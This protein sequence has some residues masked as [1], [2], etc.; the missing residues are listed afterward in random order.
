LDKAIQ[1]V[2]RTNLTSVNINPDPF[3][4]EYSQILS[5]TVKPVEGTSSE[6]VEQHLRDLGCYK[7]KP[8]SVAKLKVLL[9]SFLMQAQRLEEK[10]KRKGERRIIGW[11]HSESYWGTRSSIGYKLAREL[12]EALVHHGWI[13]HEVTAEINLYL[14]NGHCHGY[15]IDD[16]VLDKAKDLA[17]TSSHNFIYPTKC[18]KTPV[19][20]ED[21]IDNR[22]RALWALWQTAPLT[23]GNVEMSVAQRSFSNKELN[24]GGRFYGNWTTMKKEA[25]LACILLFQQ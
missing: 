9:A 25:R 4:H 6:V 12:R 15:L 18:S 2:T 22:T 7:T 24:R 10:R 16:L 20:N 11:P 1:Q 13:K 19:K 17:F 8:T 5:P 21:A 23:H 14:G 3:R